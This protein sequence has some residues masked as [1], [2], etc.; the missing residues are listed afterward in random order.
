[1]APILSKLFLS[2][3]SF[4]LYGTLVSPIV[5]RAGEPVGTTARGMAK[6]VIKGAI[7][8]GNAVQKAV[9]NAKEAIDDIAAEAKS[10]LAGKEAGAGAPSAPGASVA[11]TEIIPT[12]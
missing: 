4:F 1:M 12:A 11:N 6:S 9:L 10:E 3:G 8:A 2:R 5:N 7:T